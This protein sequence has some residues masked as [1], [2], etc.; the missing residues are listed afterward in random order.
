MLDKKSTFFENVHTHRFLAEL[1]TTCVL[2]SPPLF[3]DVLRSEVDDAGIDLVLT[4]GAQVR[5]IQLKARA[6]SVPPKPYAI[7]KRLLR[8][9]GGAI[10]WIRYSKETLLA[11]DYY[12]LIGEIDQ[13]IDDIF[14][15]FK[16]VPNKKGL[17]R[18]GYSL[19]PMRKANRPGIA[20]GTL[21][22]LLFPKNP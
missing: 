11:Y 19:V 4:S 13:R 10:V 1:L 22:E 5:Y 18:E 17:P 14:G 21:A 3:L 15:P 7:S 12:A 9:P 2:R 8:M 6:E 20:V 16:T